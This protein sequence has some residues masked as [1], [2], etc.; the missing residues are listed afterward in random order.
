MLFG[1]GLH[2]SQPHPHSAL[3]GSLGPPQRPGGCDSALDLCSDSEAA[4]REPH[5]AADPPSQS[6]LRVSGWSCHKVSAPCIRQPQLHPWHSQGKV[7]CGLLTS[8]PFLGQYPELHS[9]TVPPVHPDSPSRPSY[10]P[11][12]EAQSARIFPQDPPEK[13]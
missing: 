8:Q 4:Y 10:C 7:G 3:G 9:H 13:S 2:P 12:N 5:R 1:K 11:Q 6:G